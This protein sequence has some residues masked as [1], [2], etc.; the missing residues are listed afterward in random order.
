MERLRY[1]NL[2]YTN[3]YILN[4]NINTHIIEYIHDIEESNNQQPQRKYYY[5]SE[6]VK[7]YCLKQFGRYQMIYGQEFVFS[8]SW[9]EMADIINI[10]LYLLNLHM[11]LNM[12]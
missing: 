6:I 10:L 7:D 4:S 2:V 11:T 5:Y 3:S 8:F 1:H 9:P 12:A